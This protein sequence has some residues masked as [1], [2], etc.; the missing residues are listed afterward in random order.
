MAWTFVSEWHEPLRQ[1]L[2]PRKGNV[3]TTSEWSEL[4]FIRS[5]KMSKLT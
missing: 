3:L 4:H 5:D 2:I 1:A